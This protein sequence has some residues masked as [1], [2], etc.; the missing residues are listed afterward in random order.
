MGEVKT[1]RQHILETK[2]IIRGSADKKENP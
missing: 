2:L 1:P